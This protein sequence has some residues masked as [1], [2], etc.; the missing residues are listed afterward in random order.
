M[1]DRGRVPFALVGVL[2]L[3]SSATLAPALTERSSPG[4]PDV[5]VAM[6]R[7]TAQARGALE[8]GAERAARLAA[9]EPVLTRSNTTYG[10]VLNRTDTFR[11]AL[12]VRVY[13]R[14]RDHL[15]RTAVTR[16]GLTLNAS[17]PAA[18]SP[19]E[20]RRAKRRVRVAPAGP[21]AT[22]LA[23]SV[24]PITL[25]AR[26]DGRL[27]ANRTF[28]PSVV[29]PIPVL[30]V[31][32][33]V[34][35]FESLLTGGPLEPGLGRLLT[36]K[37]Y[38]ATW[39]RGYAQWKGLPIQNVLA[40]R[41]LALLTNGAVLSVQRRVFG[42]SDPVG[43]RVHGWRTLSATVLDVL[44]AKSPDTLARLR[45]ARRLLDLLD[46]SKG[47]D[48]A[49][50]TG[51]VDFPVP[52]D[53]VRVGV[54]ASAD[55]AFLTVLN[56]LNE[57]IRST[58]TAAVRRTATVASRRGSAPTAPAPPGQE[59]TLVHDHNSTAVTVEDRRATPA[60]A[61]DDRHLLRAYPRR[62]TLDHEWTRRWV[63]NGSVH[64]RTT[65]GTEVVTLTV[66]LEGDHRL[67]PAPDRPIE[68]VHE[69]GGPFDGPNLADIEPAAI[70]R[71]V[72]AAGG[73]AAI[74]ERVA[75][76]G[77]NE[78]TVEI[79]GDRPPELYGWL[80]RDLVELRQRVRNVTVNTTRGKLATFQA[81][82]ARALRE[83]VR[84]RS[85]LLAPVPARFSH[86]AHRARVGVRRAF[87]GAVDVELG[88][89]ALHRSRSRDK[90]KDRLS[91]MGN[92]SVAALQEGYSTRNDW[93]ALTPAGVEMRV[94]A[95]PA[96]L[97]TAETTQR[98]LPAL[99]ENETLHPLV[100]R[101]VNFFTLPYGGF[102]DAILSIL[103]PEH[104]RLRT[105]AQ[106]LQSARRLDRVNESADTHPKVRT[107]R[108]RTRASL[109]TVTR[110]ISP[111][112]AQRFRGDNTTWFRLF[113]E[114]LATYGAPR[115]RAF[116]VANGSVVGSL[117][118]AA[119]AEWPD[120]GSDP[121][122][123]DRVAVATAVGLREIRTQK[124]SGPQKGAADG[125]IDRL[126]TTLSSELSE[127]FDGA[128]RNV[129]MEAV[130]AVTEIAGTQL[131]SGLPVAPAPGLWYATVNGWRAQARGEYAR[132]AVIVPR[133]TP[134]TPGAAMAYVRD[135]ATVRLDVNGDGTA[136]R[137]GTASRV[138]F[139]TD[140]WIGVAVPPGSPG[141]GDK[142][143]V[144]NE[145]SAGWP[146]PSDP[147]ATD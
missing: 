91:D 122:W 104:V 79:T 94:N 33:R 121:V 75:R 144:R 56:D 54:N 44:S 100:V 142:D 27:V 126:R 42:E 53:R 124:Q 96:Y 89:R 78:T 83:E 134:A 128:V 115:H 88:V 45:E 50:L 70:D 73:P 125:A 6:E 30:A 13:R 32:D 40:N 52:S 137:L 18:T 130:R 86:V 138:S 69:S 74:A 46:S 147:P 43:R 51:H 145:T 85:G 49:V 47:A 11:D 102:A 71:L 39:A 35:T 109:A 5:D 16:R 127:R 105:G 123:R 103:S 10:R 139:R 132:F 112:L 90:T 140:T 133:G 15:Q 48:T 110:R 61:A 141:V 7:F 93:A 29:V 8:T 82:P 99:G 66:R 59:W 65:T 38:M 3:V 17:L 4:Q 92:G 34:S 76:T 87:L 120:A 108:A 21:N 84:N 36:A 119:R 131:P 72:T 58:Y 98:A 37:L 9:R 62:V 57:T 22:A 64:Q 135:G 63:H 19:A 68:T 77:A 1:T 67:P 80:Y 118:A 136:E 14:V 60:P 20:L 146:W 41:H 101:N 95:A 2:L 25:T 107:L 113:E 129:T 12:R 116:A 24:G 143:G 55:D 23:V 111:R 114:A 81:T 31:H 26:R 28:A 97:T 117:L 106:V